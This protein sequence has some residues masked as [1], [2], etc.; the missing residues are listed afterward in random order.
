M[1]SSSCYQLSHIW[2]EN[3]SCFQ[4][5]FTT[6][7]STPNHL[8]K[9]LVYIVCLGLPNVWGPRTSTSCTNWGDLNLDPS[10]SHELHW[11]LLLVGPV[12]FLNWK[13]APNSFSPGIFW[14]RGTLPPVTGT[15][16]PWPWTLNMHTMVSP[17][18][19]SGQKEEPSSQPN[20]WSWT[21]TDQFC[22]DVSS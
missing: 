3:Y 9:D 19:L 15:R 10:L 22:P 12:G 21:T 13:F 17:M 18:T 16:T 11:L 2:Y 14:L 8:K 6:C 4:L 5:C 7:S 20:C 1:S